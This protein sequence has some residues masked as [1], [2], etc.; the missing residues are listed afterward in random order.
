VCV[1]NTT[2]A[3]VYL[4]HYIIGRDSVHGGGLK[5]LIELGGAWVGQDILVVVVIVYVMSLK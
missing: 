5:M 1:C 2:S 3:Y 4:C